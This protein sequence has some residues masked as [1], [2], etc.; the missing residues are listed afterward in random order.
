MNSPIGKFVL[1]AFLVTAFAFAQAPKQPETSKPAP[2]NLAWSYNHDKWKTGPTDIVQKWRAYTVSFDSDDDDNGDAQADRWGIPHWV[3]YQVKK[4]APLP[5]GPE[6]PSPWITDLALFAKGICPA[7]ESYHYPKTIKNR[8]PYDRGHMC[9][10][11]TAFRMGP[12]ADWNTHTLVNACPQHSDL[13]QG[14]WEDLER[15]YGW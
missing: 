15:R 1:L 11:F 4:H 9:A 8:P 10:K 14:I 13:N 2:N 7:D 3:A 12:E 5:K 6:R